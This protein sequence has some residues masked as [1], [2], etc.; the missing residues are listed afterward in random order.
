[1]QD[2]V[3]QQSL[4]VALRKALRERNALPAF[5]SNVERLLELVQSDADMPKIAAEIE[6]DPAMATRILKVANSAFYGLSRQVATL[7]LAVVL[8]GL[9]NVHNIVLGVGF[10]QMLQEHELESPYPGPDFLEHSLR[11]GR[12]ARFLARCCREE[13]HGEEFV[14][15]LIH[16]I[17]KLALLRAFPEEVV[18]GIDELVGPSLVGDLSKRPQ[19]ADLV[20]V[21]QQLF[22]VDHAHVG[23]WAA[24]EWQLPAVIATAIED[25]HTPGV[26]SG[27]AALVAAAD[28]TAH[29]LD[30]SSGAG[31][32]TFPE[33]SLPAQLLQRCGQPAECDVAQLRA[34]CLG[35]D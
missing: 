29:W 25:H 12:I 30:S 28:W 20:A 2:E 9:R 34:A 10:A 32:T 33:E 13:H 14:A 22:G 31:A 21:E 7:D 24:V 3:T 5:P 6:H 18:A 26:T 11:T 4:S 35:R 1:M 8:L 23:G 27:L 15:G 16:D 19:G 17:G